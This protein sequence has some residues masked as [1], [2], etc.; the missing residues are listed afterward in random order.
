VT[1][2]DRIADWLA[3]AGPSTCEQI[4]R[5][6]RTR[7]AAVREVLQTDP[8]V[9]S[10]SGSGRG[11]EYALRASQ[12]AVGL[13]PGQNRASRLYEALRDRERHSRREIFD[14]VGFM[15]TNNAASELREKIK[16]R[17]LDV[18]HTVEHRVD[19]YQIV[20]LNGEVEEARQTGAGVAQAL[21]E[22]SRT[23]GE[24]AGSI[25][26]PGPQ[27]DS[28]PTRASSTSSHLHAGSQLEFPSAA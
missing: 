12:D 26:V 14:R 20:S 9:T 13:V 1:L 6:V 16:P 21:A 4:A 5:G 3:L 27:S 15:L 10:H 18:I 2:A 17:G 19:C 8:R 25:P 11:R 7:T 28:R 24:V 23:E 22:R